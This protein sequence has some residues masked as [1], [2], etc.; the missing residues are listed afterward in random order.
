MRREDIQECVDVFIETFSAAP[1]YDVYEDRELVVKY[2]ENFLANNYFVGYI[3]KEES[4][5][6]ALSVGMQKPY[7]KRNGIL[8]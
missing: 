4:E 3:W 8:Y 1:W 2:F 5:I 7:I 6:L